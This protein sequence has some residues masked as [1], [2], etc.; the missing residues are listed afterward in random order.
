MKD[1]PISLYLGIDLDEDMSIY[2]EEPLNIS[3]TLTFTEIHYLKYINEDTKRKLE[4]LERQYKQEKLSEEEYNRRRRELESQLKAIPEIEL[5]SRENPWYKMI[6][7]EVKEN[8]EWRDCNWKIDIITYTPKDD[9]IMLKT[10]ELYMTC[11][12]IPPEETKKLKQGEYTI[13]A[14]LENLGQKHYSNE[15]VFKKIDGERRGVNFEN[16]MRLADYH[17]RYGDPE[18]AKPIIDE[19]LRKKDTIIAG[20]ILQALYH[21]RKDDKKKALDILEKA[22]DKFYELYPDSREHPRAITLLM[23]KIMKDIEDIGE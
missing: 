22:L 17:V 14:V 4:Y 20:M 18:K 7:F 13:R 1:L 5:G 15:V 19:F 12:V 2:D 11:Y 23:Y 21:L 3:V 16:N 10:D 6:R 9:M 8:G